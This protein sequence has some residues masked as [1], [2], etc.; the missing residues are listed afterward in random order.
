M[1]FDINSF[2]NIIKNLGAA[3]ANAEEDKN[4][5][6]TKKEVNAFA[7][8]CDDIKSK[9]KTQGAE[10]SDLSKLESLMSET[11]SDFLSVEFSTKAEGAKAEKAQSNEPVFTG[12]LVEEMVNLLA[13]DDN[14]DIDKLREYNKKEV[15]T[16]DTTI[17]REDLIE[18]GY[19]ETI[20]DELLET[21]PNALKYISND[22]KSGRAKK[23]EQDTIAMTG[24]P[25]V[26]WGVAGHLTAIGND[27]A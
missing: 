2:G 24:F 7:L 10:T 21:T 5:I 23:I 16:I 11:L 25:P 3:S 26:L 20:V 8:G 12:N 6:D 4:K 14:L 9:A 19:D 17:A 18:A 22:I 27:I 13:D 15:A 1:G